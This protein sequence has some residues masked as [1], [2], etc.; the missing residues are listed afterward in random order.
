MAFTKL[1]IGTS[2]NQDFTPLLLSVQLSLQ[3]LICTYYFWKIQFKDHTTLKTPTFNILILSFNSSDR[4]NWFLPHG[5][6]F[7]IFSAFLHLHRNGLGF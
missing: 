4:L 7:A 3:I 1:Q 2:Y 6:L 5:F